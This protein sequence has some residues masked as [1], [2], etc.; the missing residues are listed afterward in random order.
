MKALTASEMRE[1]DR[2]TTERFGISGT[3]LMEN[4]G[5]SVAEVIHDY[6]VRRRNDRPQRVAVLCGKGNNGGDGFVVAR[7]LLKD[8]LRFHVLLYLFGSPEDLQGAT[9]ENLRQ[10]RKS[11]GE[12]KVIDSEA[13]W[14]KAWEAIAFAEIVVD[15]LLGTGLRGSP[16]GPLAKAI[17]Q[18]NTHSRNLKSP[19]PALILAVDT[20]SG[21][22]SD[23]EAAPGPVLRTHKTV[24]FTAPKIGQ[25]ISPDASCCGELTVKFI[26]TP[27]S[28]V[29]EIGKG[30]LRWAGP[31]EF[32]SLPLVRSAESHKGTF[33]HAMII[34]GS[35]GKSGAAILAGQ[36]ALRSGAG[37]TTVATPDCVQSTIAS[38]HPEYMTEALASTAEGTIDASNLSSGVLPKILRGK[39][40]LGVGP[41]LG[42]NSGTQEFIRAVVCESEVPLIL[43]ADGLNAF[44]EDADQLRNRKSPFLA[45][46][47]HPGE[48]ARLLGTTNQSVQSDRL[49]VAREAARRWN[50]HVVLKGYH[51]LIAAPGGEVWVNTTGSAGLAKGGSGDVLTGVLAALTAQFGT[52]EWI[53]VLA[54]GVY[55]H[56]AAGSFAGGWQDQSGLLASEVAFAVP[57]MRHALVEEI[58][59]G[60]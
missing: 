43:D 1:V 38:A 35:R 55:L 51:S 52:A 14:E 5:Q 36:A 3:Q 46:T 53:R 23:G 7:H 30:T 22:P 29:E 34:G 17:S 48:M 18:L 13:D 10:W 40:A 47:P 39:T 2:L 25:L 59:R 49:S 41:G 6:C 56:G 50:V 4:A 11:G 58:R 45:I 37:L 20:P 31:G 15:A 44:A 42:T 9:A 54:L 8:Q 32:A 60:G 16:T 12:V 24:T 21:L 27:N 33:G 19:T 28:L 26:G 57:M